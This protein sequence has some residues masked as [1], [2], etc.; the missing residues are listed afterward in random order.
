MHVFKTHTIG[1][2]INIRLQKLALHWTGETGKLADLQD[3]NDTLPYLPFEWNYIQ[4]VYEV[5]V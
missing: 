3:M 1:L 2:A 5:H 4:D